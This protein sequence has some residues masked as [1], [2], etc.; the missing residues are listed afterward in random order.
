MVAQNLAFS[1][2]AQEAFKEFNATSCSGS[3]LGPTELPPFQIIPS[4]VL[5]HATRQLV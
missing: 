4:E 5:Q 3:A 1:F 2:Y